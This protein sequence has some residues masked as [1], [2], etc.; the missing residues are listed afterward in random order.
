MSLFHCG[1]VTTD[2][3]N[4]VQAVSVIHCEAVKPKEKL[5]KTLIKTTEDDGTD[6]KNRICGEGKLSVVPPLHKIASVFT[7][8]L[9]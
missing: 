9:R 2:F 4:A 7:S 8:N 6:K 5:N 3:N 1:D